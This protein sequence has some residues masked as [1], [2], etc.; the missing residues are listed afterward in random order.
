MKILKVDRWALSL[1]G[2]LTRGVRMFQYVLLAIQHSVS[3]KK[4]ISQSLIEKI[5]EKI[6][7]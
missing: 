2:F 5:F 1:N 3:C 6:N 4:N 7:K